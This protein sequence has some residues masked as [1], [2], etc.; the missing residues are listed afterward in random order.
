MHA[1]AQTFCKL[2][3][4]TV[5]K[6]PPVFPRTP[7]QRSNQESC[8]TNGFRCAPWL[9]VFVRARVLAEC[10]CTSARASMRTCVHTCGRARGPTG[11]GPFC[12]CLCAQI[13]RRPIHLI[14]A[15][16]AMPR[17]Q[18]EVATPEQIRS[19]FLSFKQLKSES[20]IG[21]SLRA[22]LHRTTPHTQK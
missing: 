21:I 2:T 14:L 16:Q 10:W 8:Q 3:C 5:D 18:V 11:G 13:M 22:A 17:P 7:R 9:C 4:L 15:R 12:L 20:G 6:P 19:P 1:Q